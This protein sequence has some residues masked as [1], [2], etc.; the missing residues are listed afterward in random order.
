MRRLTILFTKSKKRLPLFSWLIRLIWDTEYSHT[1]LV[2]HSKSYNRNLI[3]HASSVGLNFSSERVF[4]DQHEVVY[5]QEIE[6]SEEAYRNIIIQSI[7]LAG[8][9]YGFLQS[10]GI[11]LAYLASK[12]G[13]PKSNPFADG[14]DKWVCSEWV[15]K[16]LSEVYPEYKPDL[17]TVSPKEVYTFVK[18]IDQG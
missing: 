9:K 4:N 1:A 6:V 5:S 18:S 16:A 10:I 13:L 2:F 12:L 11:G 3:Y 17:E 14:R 7:D 15:A 8:L